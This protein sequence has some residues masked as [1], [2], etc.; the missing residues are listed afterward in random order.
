MWKFYCKCFFDVFYDI[1]INKEYVFYKKR[2]RVLKVIV[3]VK[4]GISFCLF[5]V[6]NL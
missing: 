6:E 2:I 1:I 4:E 3:K 5:Y